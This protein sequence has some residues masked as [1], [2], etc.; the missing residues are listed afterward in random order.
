MTLTTTPEVIARCF[1]EHGE[2]MY[3]AALAIVRNPHDAEDAVQTAAA[4]ALAAVESFRGE[5]STCTWIHRIVINASTDQVRRR[6]RDGHSLDEDAVDALWA[7]PNFSV[8]PALVAAAADDRRRLE[9]ALDR[10]SDAQR[11]VV[12]LHDAEDWTV[13]EIARTVEA[14]LATVKSHLRRGRQALV[15]ILGTRP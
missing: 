8:D 12:L 7:D 14:P 6:R 3:R 9:A 5:A 13:A 11:Q 10:L 1:E 15:V 4:R 2:R